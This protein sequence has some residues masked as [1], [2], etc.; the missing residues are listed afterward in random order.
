MLCMSP[1]I[2]KIDWL[3]L[4]GPTESVLRERLWNLG[5]YVGCNGA[6]GVLRRFV[7]KHFVYDATKLRVSPYILLQNQLENTV[8]CDLDNPKCECCKTVKTFLLNESGTIRKCEKLLFIVCY[9][10][11]IRT[12]E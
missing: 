11:N 4:K 3:F 10:F 12:L 6:G 2:V 9:F 8:S 1:V 7:C 5:V